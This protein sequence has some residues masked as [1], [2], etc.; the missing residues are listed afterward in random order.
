[1]RVN[2]QYSIDT[3]ELPEITGTLIKKAIESIDMDSL[4]KLSQPYELLSLETAETIDALRQALATTDALLQDAHNIIMGWV[5][6]K[7][8]PP[9]AENDAPSVIAPE[10]LQA[11][12]AAFKTSLDAQQANEAAD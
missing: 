2:I 6:Y 7:S 10:E 12:L 3:E 4:E 1:M 11:K 9:V 8:T 5:R